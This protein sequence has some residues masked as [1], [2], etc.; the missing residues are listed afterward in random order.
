MPKFMELLGK[1]SIYIYREQAHE[2][3]HIHIYQGSP[4]SPERSAVIALDNWEVLENKGFKL[5]RLE[6]ICEVI[7]DNEDELRTLWKELNDDN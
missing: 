7:T 4:K 5:S 6:E 1:I 2:R 3:M